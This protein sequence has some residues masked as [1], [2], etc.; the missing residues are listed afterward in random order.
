MNQKQIPYRIALVGVGKAQ[1]DTPKDGCKIGYIHAEMLAKQ[2]RGNLA[3]GVDISDEN[4]RVW[5]EKFGISKGYTDYAEMLRD[6]KPDVVAL[7]TYVGLH[8][9]M[10][11]S[12]ARA[13]VKGIFCEKPFLNSPAEIGKLR[14]LIEETGVKIVVNHMRR[15]Q[16][17][18]IHAKALID[19]GRIGKPEMMSAGVAGWDL[20][21]WGAHWLDI[22]RFLNSDCPVKWAFGQT[23]TRDLRAFGHQM[24]EHGMGYFRF[25]NECNAILDGGNAIGSYCMQIQGSEGTIRLLNEGKGILQTKD[26]FEEFTLPSYGSDVW[27]GVWNALFDWM[28][29]GPEPDLGASNQL[30]TSELNLAL[31][32]SALTGDRVDFPLTSD[33]DVWP[34]DA[35]V[36]KNQAGSLK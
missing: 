22:F 4:L 24:E 1:K 23:R 6:L 20:S 9:P 32:V 11:E 8:Y 36:R 33:L 29:G 3:A 35:I 7:A 13:G 15:Y 28:E 34:V 12:A 31:Y 5:S 18:F 14:A 17:I 30:L 16:P 21:E 27:L 25:E 19:A 26:G 10:I 2:T